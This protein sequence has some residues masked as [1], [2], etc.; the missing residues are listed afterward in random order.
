MAFGDAYV[1]AAALKAYLGI[2]DADDDALLTSACLS[3]SVAVEQFCQRQFNKA[4]SATPEARVFEARSGRRLE[5]DDFYTATGLIVATDDSDT[6]SYSTTWT[7]TTDYVL[8]P[9]G[10]IDLG[11]A[12]FPFSRIRAVGG[13]T[14]PCRSGRYRVQVTATYGWSAVPESVKEA[15]K[16]IAA[17][18]YNTKNAPLG[19]ASF[20][21][22]VIIRV[23]EDVPQAAML[24]KRYQNPSRTGVLVA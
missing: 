5:V 23:R 22:S 12:S 3:A 19:V 24:L 4:A 16:M 21:D 14:W 20:T 10:G 6:G 15:T 9:P 13:R 2:T 1:D 7:L 18:I 17:R 8:E 11:V